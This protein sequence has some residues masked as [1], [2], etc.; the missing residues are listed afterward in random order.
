MN[1]TETISDEPRLMASISAQPDEDTHR[2]A[3]ADWLQENGQGERAEFI[4]VQC[5]LAKLPKPESLTIGVIPLQGDP[6]TPMCKH[7]CRECRQAV[8]LCRYHVLV[9]REQELLRRCREMFTFVGVTQSLEAFW[10]HPD[11]R[12]VF[13]VVLRRGFV[14]EITCTTA[15]WLKYADALYWHPTQTV[16]C[17]RCVN[18]PNDRDRCLCKGKL[19]RPFVPTAHPI[20][21]VSLTTMPEVGLMLGDSIF[22]QLRGGV[23]EWRHIRWPGITFVLPPVTDRVTVGDSDT[24]LPAS[25]W[26]ITGAE[27]NDDYD[28]FTYRENRSTRILPRRLNDPILELTLD[29]PAATRAATPFALP[30]ERGHR[31]GPVIATTPTPSTITPGHRVQCEAVIRDVSLD[32]HGNFRCVAQSAGPIIELGMTT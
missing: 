30:S 24:Y 25:G 29:I 20:R 23:N 9:R 7:T 28:D 4:R 14:E 5:E 15:D 6:K 1:E 13:P 21:R 12:V 26:I 32:E 3:Y 22:V 17:T 2:L 27:R 10:G 19:A 16:W 11:E 18:Y 8:D 31:F